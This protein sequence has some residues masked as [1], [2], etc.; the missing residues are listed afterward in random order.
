MPCRRHVVGLTSQ[1]RKTLKKLINTGQT[2]VYRQRHD[3][4][5][6]LRCPHHGR[7]PRRSGKL[8][9]A[10][11]TL[12]SLRLSEV[13]DMIDRYF[14]KCTK[15]GHR[16][17]VFTAHCDRFG[18]TPLKCKVCE[19]WFEYSCKGYDGKYRE[20][21][22]GPCRIEGDTYPVEYIDK[23]NGQAFA[24]PKKCALC[25]FIQVRCSRVVCSADA[26]IWGDFPRGL[27]WGDWHL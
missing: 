12:S 15:K 25:E 2:A 17:P 10:V 14:P 9:G 6:D 22:Y 19:N 4:Q 18:A 3:R 21:D 20:S 1:E 16:D 27:D 24:V 13:V 8:R 7:E 5:R 23:I 26:K 11:V